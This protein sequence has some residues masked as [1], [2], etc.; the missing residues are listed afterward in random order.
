MS[1]YIEEFNK[2]ILRERRQEEQVERVERYLNGL[3][4]GIQDEI[5]MMAL[6]S[7]HKCFQLALREEEKERRRHDSQQRVRGNI[8]FRGRGNFGRGPRPSRLE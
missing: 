3:R 4:Q 7:M 5:N 6:D 8:G 2:L 1:A